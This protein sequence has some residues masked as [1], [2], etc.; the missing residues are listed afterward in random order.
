MKE[1]MKGVN[2]NPAEEKPSLMFLFSKKILEDKKAISDHLE[3]GGELEDLKDQ[4]NFYM[5]CT[6]KEFNEYLAAEYGTKIF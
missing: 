3:K 4:Y 1:K 6:P 2:V 5:P